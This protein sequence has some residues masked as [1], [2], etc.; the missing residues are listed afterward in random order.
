MGGLFELKELEKR[1]YPR[2]TSPIHYPK[3][4]SLLFLENP[5]RL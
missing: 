1:I 2:P 5:E 4:K 3:L